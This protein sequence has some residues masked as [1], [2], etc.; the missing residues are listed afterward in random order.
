MIEFQTNSKFKEQSSVSAFLLVDKPK[1]ITSFF[2]VKVF[3]RLFDMKKIGYAG[4]LDPLASGLMIFAFGKATKLLHCLEGLDKTYDVTVRF[5]A[6]SETYDAEGPIHPY[7]KPVKDDFVGTKHC[8]VPTKSSIEEAIKKHFQGQQI[9]KPPIYSAQKIKGE[10]AYSLARRGQT[11][12][13]KSKTVTFFRV[14]IN[15]F[16][17]PIL[18]CSVHCGSGT[19]IRSFAHDLGQI[20]QCGAYVEALRRVKIGSI[21]VE[22]AI[23]FEKITAITCRDFLVNSI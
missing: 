22:N 15:H 3:R 20:L 17:Y 9:Q 6:V 11:P 12:D 14:D 19:Y 7:E 8:S 13:V 23:S 5:G 1:G 18:E 10:H 21:S 16:S 2:M 4:T